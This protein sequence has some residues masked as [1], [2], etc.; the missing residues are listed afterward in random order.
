MK[1]KRPVL[2][3]G[4]AGWALAIGAGLS[5]GVPSPG[6]DGWRQKLV[7]W[8]DRYDEPWAKPRMAAEFLGPRGFRVVD[9][10]ELGRWM[11][12]VTD[13]NQAVRTVVVL[14]HGLCP[15]SIAD[16]DERTRRFS[17]VKGGNPLVRRYM[18]VGGRVVWSGELPFYY[19]EGTRVALM[20]MGAALTAPGSI[21]APDPMAV[22]ADIKGVPW[23][24]GKVT[25]TAEG[26]RWGL[27]HGRG[28]KGAVRKDTVTVSLCDGPGTNTSV[29]YFKNLNKAYPHSGFVCSAITIGVE[30]LY[31]L[32]LYRGKP[33]AVP[34]VETPPK[35]V[36]TTELTLAVRG[37]APDVRRTAFLRGERLR[38]T[39]DLTNRLAPFR[40]TTTLSVTDER[41]QAAFRQQ[42]PGLLPEGT[43]PVRSLVLATGDMRLGDYTVRAV[44]EKGKQV[45]V[46]AEA[47]FYLRH[48]SRNPFFL[49]LWMPGVY[50]PYRQRILMEEVR[51]M[52]VEPVCGATL[53][54]MALRHGLRFTRRIEGP[55]GFPPA[56]AATTQNEPFLLLD[57]HLKPK[58]NPWAP[59]LYSVGLA[60]P[61]VWHGRAEGTR[62]QIQQLAA[63]PNLVRFIPTND[64]FQE[65]YRMNWSPYCREW[66]KALTGKDAPFLK[67]DKIGR[68]VRAKGIIPDD[69]TWLEWKL[70][71]ADQ[72]NGGYNRTVREAKDR[73]MPGARIGPVTGMQVPFWYDSTY[74]PVHYRGFDLLSYYYY[75]V[76]WQPLVGN[77]W[78]PEVVRMANRG[79]PQMVTPDVVTLEETTY[80]KNTFY[81][82]LAG[83]VHSLTYYAYSSMKPQGRRFL[84]QEAVPVIRR[85]GPVIARLKPARRR[86][87]LYLSV[88]HQAFEWDYPLRAIY[89]YA[90]LLG[91][92][93]D[94]EP[95]C[96]EELLAPAVHR[97]DALVLW[98]TDWL[99]QSEVAGLQAYMKR[100][101][102]VF[103]DVGCEAVVPGA[104]R[105]DFGIAMGKVNKPNSHPNDM[106]VGAPALRDYLVP[107]HVQAIAQSALGRFT[108]PIE[109][110]SP[111]VVVRTFEAAGAQY[112]WLVSIHDH[113]E[114]T[115]ITFRTRAGLKMPDPLKAQQ[116]VTDFLKARGVYDKPVVCPVKL[117]PTPGAVYDLSKGRALPVA[118]GTCTVTMDRLGGTLI[119]L[120]PSAVQEVRVTV[121]TPKPKPGTDVLYEVRVMGA[122][123]R[124]MRGLVPIAIELK[125]AA[126]AVQAEYSAT[127]VA[128]AGRYLGDFTPAKNSPKGQWRLTVKELL[129]GKAATVAIGI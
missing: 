120:Y 43:H 25:V 61:R 103:Q 12:D 81:L 5:A 83:G 44:V 54:D 74:P 126:G 110:Q 58:S 17:G 77:L 62:K 31:R 122:D 59:S 94:V 45:V 125:D 18:D 56:L 32:A 111:T 3:A 84:T 23:P 28:T 124:M 101:G 55:E 86:V 109:P 47:R 119:G 112:A 68:P 35:P 75:L 63:Y 76:Y 82:T 1:T 105:L 90:N 70:F 42:W 49:A 14:P 53:A 96:R 33:V 13:A 129:S 93:V 67:V 97:Y 24:A 8:D 114:F 128:E 48:V 10:D 19:A 16:I 20:S 104:Q 51:D 27:R 30:E 95:T 80:Y 46:A 9:A 50:K 11:R 106:R 65:Y 64:D 88:A 78:W 6:S 52:G 108:T 72:V 29:I 87:G 15:F 79:K 36:P 26:K 39:V 4:V 99:S 91:A 127:D 40:G 7:F 60:H 34:R 100:G 121:H 116:E 123:G 92:H 117:P 73:V 41:G 115:Y 57:K 66:F 113:D 98:N 118:G 2:L 102:V 69:D 71:I 85:L 21:Q 89:P 38:I 22:I 37:K 107:A